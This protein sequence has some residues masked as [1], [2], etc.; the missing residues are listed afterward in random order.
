MFIQLKQLVNL[1]NFRMCDVY[2]LLSAC[3]N[4]LFLF[5]YVNFHIFL[6][7]CMQLQYVTHFVNS[8]CS[9]INSKK[10]SSVVRVHACAATI[11]QIWQY[12]HIVTC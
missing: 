9:F 2:V 1:W 6:I 12:V 5:L 4:A 10:P 3:V 7:F 8:L 11:I